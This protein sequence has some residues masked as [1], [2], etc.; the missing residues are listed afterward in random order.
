MVL[1]TLPEYSDFLDD[2]E[3]EDEAQEPDDKDEEENCTYE[4]FNYLG[5]IVACITFYFHP[6]LDSNLKICQY[7]EIKKVEID[8]MYELELPTNIINWILGIGDH[9]GAYGDAFKNK[10]SRLNCFHCPERYI[11]VKVPIPTKDWITGTTFQVAR[12]PLLLHN[13]IIKYFDSPA[14]YSAAFGGFKR[15]DIARH[16]AGFLKS[17]SFYE[18]KNDRL[19][20]IRGNVPRS[21]GQ[22][23]LRWA[24]VLFRVDTNRTQILEVIA[25]ECECVIGNTER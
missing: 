17:I 14:F 3:E 5:F 12:V 20:G 25:A 9:N 11:R 1:P 24:K 7:H 6:V 4:P 19:F 13:L 21:L 8:R 10:F 22:K 23:P 18:N 2:D 15:Y 16:S